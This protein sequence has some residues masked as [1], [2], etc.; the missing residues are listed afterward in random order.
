M[1]VTIRPLPLAAACLL[2]LGLAACTTERPTAAEP[3]APNACKAEA[4]RFAVGQT[5]SD[6]LAEQAR[7]ASGARSV[8]GLFPGQAVTMDYRQDRLNLRV[9]ESQRVTD[10]NCG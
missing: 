1:I 9:D 2:G 8:R 3:P 10:V 7:E 6:A 4:A 5:W